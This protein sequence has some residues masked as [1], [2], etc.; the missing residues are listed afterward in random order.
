MKWT[1]AYLLVSLLAALFLLAIG[2]GPL[3]GQD[4]ARPSATNPLNISDQGATGDGMTDDTA[5]IQAALD[6]VA[7]FGG[8]TVLVPPGTYLVSLKENA[9]ITGQATALLMGS[10]TTLHLARGATLK[11]APGQTTQQPSAIIRNRGAFAAKDFDRDMLIRGE[12][13]VDGNA[14]NNPGNITN[15]IYF[16]TAQRCGVEGVTVKNCRGTAPGPPGETL[17]VSFY[18][19]GDYWLKG[20]KVLADDGGETAS[21]I[22]S[23]YSTVGRVE[24]CS[25]HGM[26]HGVGITH[27][28]SA[29]VVT[30]NCHSYLNGGNGF[31]TEFSQDILFEA[32][33]AGGEASDSDRTRNKLAVYSSRTP[34][35][36]RMGNG[37]RKAYR[38]PAGFN[39]T[40]GTRVTIRG[41][42]S[43]YNGPEAE[44]AGCGV[45]V[46]GTCSDLLID[47]VR[48]FGNRHGVDFTGGDGAEAV[49]ARMRAARI[50]P[51]TI[52]GP[53]KAA[54]GSQPNSEVMTSKGSITAS[55]GAINGYLLPAVPESGV[56][57]ANNFP[58]D[59]LV[60]LQGGA[61]TDVAVTPGGPAPAAAASLGKQ[62]LVTV[63]HGGSISV[64]YAEP[65]QW[66]WLIP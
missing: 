5:A 26:T 28:D 58:F 66:K 30:V 33:M 4:P 44:Q 9:P 35:E 43:A 8:G 62:T 15:G 45:K 32:C 46:I 47:G 12:G 10:H 31:L 13:V 51:A 20:V 59:V 54:D 23:N 50:T 57:V 48:I 16:G 11:L 6:R 29:N 27:Y 61:I 17:H 3:Y 40:S 63:P 34:E 22:G 36:A 14:A 21:G 53:N 60:S 55:R 42:M 2:P 1:P 37:R 39:I 41:G 49:N 7:T 64:S 24:D 52:L 56:A 38:G 19:C 25:V 65:P 18:R